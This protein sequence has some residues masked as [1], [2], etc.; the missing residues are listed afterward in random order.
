MA[1]VASVSVRHDL[2]LPRGGGDHVAAED[3]ADPGRVRVARL[4]DAVRSHRHARPLHF[5]RGALSWRFTSCTAP[6][7]FRDKLNLT[8]HTIYA[9]ATVLLWREG[10]PSWNHLDHVSSLDAGCTLFP[11]I[12]T[13]TF[14]VLQDHDFFQHLE[15]HMRSEHPPL[16]G[17]DHLAFRSYYFPIKVS[18]AR[19]EAR[20]VVSLRLNSQFDG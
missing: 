12:M 13:W 16:C 1:S 14:V 2:Q 5:S 15:M 3:D 19:A 7:Q 4:H 20:P 10:R 8:H 11:L 6:F 17:R 18:D 9:C